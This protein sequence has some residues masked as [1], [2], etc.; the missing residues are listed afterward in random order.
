MIKTVTSDAAWSGEADCS[1]CKLRDTVLFAG[2]RAD[3]FEHIHK[4]IEQ[5]VR[6]PGSVMYR[7]G[8]KAD[9]LFTIR[10][11]LVK[12]VQYLPDGTQRIVRLLRTSDVTGMEALLGGSYQHDAIVMQS[13]ETCDL[14]AEVVKRLSQENS[15]LHEE[16]MKRWQRALQEADLWITQLSTGS[17]KQRV[18]RLLQRL[19]CDNDTH[20]CQLFNREDMGAMLGITTETASRTIADFKR[21]GILTEK[22]H[23]VYTVDI[24]KIGKLTGD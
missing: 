6:E 2:L 18:A 23:G 8:D 19:I 3:D 7:A 1:I 10:S 4:P 11:G 17:A 13:T 22:S 21:S 14:P 5:T 24:D 16:L 12:L 9:H 20:E 15:S